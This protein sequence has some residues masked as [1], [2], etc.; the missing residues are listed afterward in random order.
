M[1]RNARL[2]GICA[3]IAFGLTIGCQSPGDPIAVGSEV[4]DFTVAKAGNIDRLVQFKDLKGKPMV[5]DFWA[6]CCAPCRASLPHL[7]QLWRENKDK[8]LQVV[9]ISIEDAGTIAQFSSTEKFDMPFFVDTKDEANNAFK[10]TGL[11][12]T[13]VIDKT[14][15]VIYSTVGMDDEAENEIKDAVAKALQ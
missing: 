15:H 7:Q 14:G 6:T 5:I 12:T 13:L 9:A 2:I 11:P 1:G 10:I 3:T 4:H 8:G